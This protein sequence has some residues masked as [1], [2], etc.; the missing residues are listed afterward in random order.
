MITFQFSAHD[1][2]DLEDWD[3]PTD[4]TTISQFNAEYWHD[5]LDEFINF[6]RGAGFI[7]EDEMIVEH[8]VETVEKSVDHGPAV[9]NS[10]VSGLSAYGDRA[11]FNDFVTGMT[12][13][14]VASDTITVCSHC[15]GSCKG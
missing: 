1:D 6:L 5:A 14:G 11:E 2:G 15:C 3:G 9:F 7:I 8:F 4:R 12:S 13:E 10:V